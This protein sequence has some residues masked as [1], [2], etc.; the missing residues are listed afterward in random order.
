VTA[1]STTA[2][3]SASHCE[4][5]KHGLR[6]TQDGIV[7]SFVLHPNQVPAALQLAQLGTRYMLALVEIGDDEKPI[8][9]K[10]EQTPVEPLAPKPAP[11]ADNAAARAP[12]KP[13]APEKRLTRIAAIL[14]A[15]PVFQSF[16]FEHD[17]ID[18]RSEEKARLAVHFIC[19]IKSRR[20]IIPGTPAG[21]EWEKLYSKFMAWKIAA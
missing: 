3:E 16:L 20:D 15:D 19:H 7:V 5:K 14:C 9:R 10:E 21:D 17:M 6:Q 2:R 13:V 11:S 12:S 1:P 4:A 8:N 18:E